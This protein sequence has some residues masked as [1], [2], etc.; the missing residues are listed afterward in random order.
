MGVLLDTMAK[1]EKRDYIEKLQEDMNTLS[2]LAKVF[3]PKN[4]IGCSDVIGL[5]PNC[6]YIKLLDDAYDEMLLASS[7]VINIQDVQ[8]QKIEEPSKKMKPY[9]EKTQ[10]KV[11]LD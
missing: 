4:E 7:G 10:R 1:Q 6:N 9:P 2:D 5:I 11:R 8:P 3:E